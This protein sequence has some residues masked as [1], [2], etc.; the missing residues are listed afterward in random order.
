VFWSCSCSEFTVQF[1]EMESSVGHVRGLNSKEIV[2]TQCYSKGVPRA[3]AVLVQ[4]EQRGPWWNVK[5]KDKF[6]DDGNYEEH[7]RTNDIFW[8]RGP[9]SRASLLRRATFAL[10]WGRSDLWPTFSVG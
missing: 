5:V 1:H 6:E 10:W 2:R 8:V 7:T 4:V 3:C 9:H